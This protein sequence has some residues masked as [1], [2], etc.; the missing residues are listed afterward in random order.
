MPSFI[1]GATTNCRVDDELPFEARSDLKGDNMFNIY[2]IYNTINNKVYI[3]V[4]T[5]TIE[6]RFKEHKYRIEERN[7]IHLYQAM[8]KYGVN[9]FHIELIDTATSQEEMFE[10][11]KYYIQQ[12]DSYYNGYN[13][14]FGGEGGLKLN[15]DEQHIITEYL[16]GKS[17]EEIAKELQVSGN[18]IR[19]RLKEYGIQLTWHKHPEE[20][21]DYII[22]E[23]IKPR[24]GKEIAQ[25]LNIS[26][27]IVS[28]ALR[29]NN[30]LRHKFTKS[31]P[32]GRQWYNEYRN[33]T[34]ISQIGIKY[35]IDRRILSRLFNYYKQI[36]EFKSKI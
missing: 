11:E 21:Y 9:Y 5:R 34:S 7:S 22:Q 23:Y 24:L 33:G 29:K 13:L 12:Y 17:S 8:K 14:T 36:D 30:I 3:G 28:Y 19:R 25:E 2:K 1:E 10:K 31:Y 20:M 6:E 4:T 15:L 35:N 27:D 18:T 26:Y 16:N 32:D